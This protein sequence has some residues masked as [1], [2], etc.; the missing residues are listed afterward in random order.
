[1]SAEQGG[2]ACYRLVGVTDERDSCDCCGRTNLKRVVVLH[3]GDD[4]V[5]IGPH[6]AAKLLG[7]SWD[8]TSPM[9]HAVTGGFNRAV[10]AATAPLQ[11]TVTVEGYL[12]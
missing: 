3:D 12:G 1:M 6:C 2:V 8:L 4:H 5:F 11:L 10:V 7:T 9:F